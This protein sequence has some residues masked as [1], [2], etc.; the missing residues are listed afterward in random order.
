[1]RTRVRL[2]PAPLRYALARSH[3]REGSLHSKASLRAERDSLQLHFVSPK[4]K[5]P[6]GAEILQIYS[7]L[8]NF[9]LG[10]AEIAEIAEIFGCAWMVNLTQKSQKSQKYYLLC[11]YLICATTRGIFPKEN[12]SALSARPLLLSRRVYSTQKSQKV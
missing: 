5:V 3:P 6:L 2:P 11:K 7:N 4:K 8:T 1:M 10:P 12:I 9:F